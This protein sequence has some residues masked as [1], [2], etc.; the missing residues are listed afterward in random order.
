[1][2]KHSEWNHIIAAFIIITI[3]FG[4]SAILS[5]D[6]TAI[7]KIILFVAIILAANL[8]AKKLTA[9][10]LDSDIEHEIWQWS[11]Y[12]FIPHWHL[13]KPI[14]AGIIFPLFLTIFSLGFLKFPAVLTYET[15]ALK[16]RTARRFGFYSYAEMTDWH[17]SLIGASG[18]VAVLLIALISYFIPG[19]EGLPK[20]ATFFAFSN[21]L[22]IS[23]L[24]GTQILFGSKVLYI[25][26]AV[27]TLI[28]FGFALFLV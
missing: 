25:L 14:P 6:A 23:K 15:K 24:D 4:F 8:L 12:G 16:H 13:K 7:G 22:P 20:L 1:M 19:L 18:I 27:I 21:M 11:R 3:V 17:N 28:A 5:L 2:S 10:A 26:L 9:K